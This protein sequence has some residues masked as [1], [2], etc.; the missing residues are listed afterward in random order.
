[1]RRLFSTLCMK[2]LT[3]SIKTTSIFHENRST[4]YTTSTSELMCWGRGSS[5]HKEWSFPLRISSV[6]VTKSAVSCEFGY[7]Y[8]RN[9][10]L[11]TSFLCSDSWNC[12]SNKSQRHHYVKHVQMQSYFWSIFSCIRTRD[13][14]R[15]VIYEVFWV[16]N[17]LE[18]LNEEMECKRKQCRTKERKSSPL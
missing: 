11:K 8:W 10:Q 12:K 17:N 16:L 15:S 14:I 5:L 1:M 13:N 3:W 9:P 6:N 7:I 18:T 4:H 2:G